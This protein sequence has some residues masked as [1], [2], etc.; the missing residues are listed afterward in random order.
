MQPRGTRGG[1]PR[2]APAD[3]GGSGGRR[4]DGG[5]PRGGPVLV[6]RGPSAGPG[7]LQD[8][9]SSMAVGV[10]R[11]GFGTAGQRTKAIVNALGM[12]ARDGMMIYH[13]DG[14]NKMLFKLPD[15]IGLITPVATDKTYPSQLNVELIKTLQHDTAP[16]IFDPAGAYDGGKNLFMPYKLDFGS[17]DSREFKV[18]LPDNDHRGDRPPPVYRVKITFAAEI[19]TTVLHRF[20]QGQQTQDEQVLTAFQAVNVIIRAD[21]IMKHPFNVRSFYPISDNRRAVGYNFELVRGYFQSVRPAIGRLLVM[22]DEIARKQTP[23]ELTKGRVDFS[24]NISAERMDNIR[25]EVQMLPY[26]QSKYVRNFGLNTQANGSFPEVDARIIKPPKLKY[27]S[28]SKQPTLEPKGGQWNMLDKKFVKPAN[29]MRWAIIIFESQNRMN[30]RQVQGIIKDYIEACRIV[31]VIV[32]EKDPVV[33]YANGQGNIPYQLKEAGHACVKK[34]GAGGPDLLVVILPGQGGGDIYRAVKHFGDCTMGVATQCLNSLKCSKATNQYWA[35]VCLKTNSKL[36]GIN[37]I[38]DTSSVPILSDP[39]NPTIIM[40][41]NIVHPTPGSNTTP[42]FTA[43]VGNVDAGA[44]KYVATSNVQESQVEIIADL[45]SM[46]KAILL[47]YKQYREAE[48]EITS[49][50]SAPKRLIFFR[51]VPEGQFTQVCDQELDIIKQVCID[52]NINVKITFIVVGKKHNYCFKPPEGGQ[53][54]KSG[55]MPAGTIIDQGITHPVEFDFYLQSHV[56]SIGMSR[57]A[58]YNVLYDDN[59]FD[60]DPLQDLCYTLCHVYARATRSVSI[61]A[62][63]YYANIVCARAKNHFDPTATATQLS[64]NAEGDLQSYRNAYKPV[65]VTMARQMYFMVL[66]F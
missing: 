51:G 4:D 65:A 50:R 26:G 49:N 30:P 25:Q 35:N 44:A 27:G 52:L 29:I 8:G 41:A 62:P 5:A 21:Q 56:D 16:Q 18:F 46:V 58:H 40:G 10:K 1:T 34:N 42:S 2:G 45:Y 37:V 32:H 55:N 33:R 59:N 14:K 11:P 48:E 13:Y 17:G 20:I 60:V 9:L 15:L 12:T 6:C 63:L 64:V 53:A 61:P 54:D 31:G 7:N 57:S 66:S 3:R 39:S 43:V 28:S 38:P 19:N 22:P 24:R 47:K 36:G 23:P